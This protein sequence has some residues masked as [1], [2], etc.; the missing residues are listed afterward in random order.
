[1]TDVYWYGHVTGLSAEAPIPKVSITD[2]ERLAGGASN[3]LRNINS[4]G[5]WVVTPDNNYWENTVWPVKNR[6]MVGDQQIARWDEN[7]SCKEILKEHLGE[8]VDRIIIADYGKGSIGHEILAHLYELNLP[9]FVDTKGDPTVYVGWVTA[10]FPN[11]SE[12]ERYAEV[13]NKFERCIVTQG[14]VGA[15]LLEFGKVIDKCPAYAT[16]VKSVC[17]AGDTFSAAYAYRW[18]RRDA[19]Q[20]ASLAAAVAVGKPMTSTVTLSEISELRRKLK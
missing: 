8:E 9:T 10:I 20:F 11:L 2:V 1:M 18:P 7:D 3:V 4:L 12:Y 14:E 6:L 19:L 15:S 16:E 17:G 5:A 13:Y